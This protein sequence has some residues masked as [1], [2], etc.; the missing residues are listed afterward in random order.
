MLLAMGRYGWD[1][2]EKEILLKVFLTHCLS[3]PL[4][5]LGYI[6]ATAI[7]IMNKTTTSFNSR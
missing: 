5:G 3:V 1:Y 4:I 7:K 6:K 2:F